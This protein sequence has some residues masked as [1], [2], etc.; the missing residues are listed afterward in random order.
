[1][2]GDTFPVHSLNPS[3]QQDDNDQ[4]GRSTS[5]QPITPVGGAAGSNEGENP[6]STG[7]SA[8][9]SIL[10]SPVLAFIKAF[11]LKSDYDSIKRSVYEHFSCE[12]VESAK[13]ALWNFCGSALDE[14]S[15]PF[16]V[17]LIYT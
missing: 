3:T 17:R 16:Q 7:N 1:M 9:H 6:P 8:S 12:L 11:R 5:A 14:A 10:I 2:K 15:L 13:K 4:H